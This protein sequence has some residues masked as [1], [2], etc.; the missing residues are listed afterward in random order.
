MQPFDV[1]RR[2]VAII[3]NDISDLEFWKTKKTW[4]QL[5]SRGAIESFAA[6]DTI[7]MHHRFGAARNINTVR[8]HS[9]ADISPGY[10]NSRMRIE[11][12][13]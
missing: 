13:R 11:C 7:I 1:G 9:L 12:D 4:A 2:R 3:R 8:A 6:H 5:L 10:S